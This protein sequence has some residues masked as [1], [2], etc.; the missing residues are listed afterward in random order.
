MPQLRDDGER[1]CARFE[2]S[3]DIE[4]A[5]VGLLACELTEPERDL[6]AAHSHG[7]SSAAI[8]EL[9]LA[10]PAR[11]RSIEPKRLACFELANE[12]V[13]TLIGGSHAL[14]AAHGPFA[15]DRKSVV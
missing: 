14:I 5:I 7:Q 12:P 11:W 4:A 10:L 15:A 9:R 1:L 3:R 2:G 8:D 6:A 13:E